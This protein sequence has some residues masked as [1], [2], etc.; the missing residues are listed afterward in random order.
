[1]RGPLEASNPHPFLH[2][3]AWRGGIYDACI[4]HFHRAGKETMKRL[5]SLM[6][7]FGLLTLLSAPRPA[8]AIFH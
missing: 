6:W 2:I 7:A 3:M 1:M 4:H 8:Q 5:G